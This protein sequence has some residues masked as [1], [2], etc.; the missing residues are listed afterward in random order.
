MRRL[1]RWVDG[2]WEN[3]LAAKQALIRL[4]SPKSI[5]PLIRMLGN[6]DGYGGEAYAAEVLQDLWDTALPTIKTGLATM[7]KGSFGP[8]LKA[9]EYD[10]TRRIAINLLVALGD[11]G[12][13]DFFVSALG[14][15]KLRWSAMTALRN[16][17]DKRAIDHLV[18]FID[19][20]DQTTREFAALAL[21]T[22]GDP[23]ATAILT[24]ASKEGR[25]DWLRTEASAVL[26]E[27]AAKALVGL[28]CKH[29]GVRELAG[30]TP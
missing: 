24:T 10:K 29:E 15:E 8:L 25:D 9:T 18:K 30:K 7:G 17:G 20:K 4:N 3:T 12:S 26:R 27:M 13:F 16:I 23:R 28:G 2:G 19:D 11:V 1:H 14:D 6:A 5:K 21:G 22:L